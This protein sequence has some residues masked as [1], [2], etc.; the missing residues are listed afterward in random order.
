MRITTH[1]V[2]P[3]MLALL[4]I[5]GTPQNVGA[6][7]GKVEQEL[8]QL[9][10]DWCNASLKNDIAWFTRVFSEDITLIS[11]AGKNTKTQA[12]ADAKAE[13]YTSCELDQMQVRLYGETAV[14]TGRTRIAGTDAKGKPI[15]DTESLW[16]DT[17]VRRAGGWQCVATQSTPVAKQ[18][19]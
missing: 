19:K 18:V 15:T 3:T 9:E 1:Y 4:V 11:P 12:I 8:M 13:K 7:Q 5:V 2:L 10:R 16:T 14:V 17:F 6:Q